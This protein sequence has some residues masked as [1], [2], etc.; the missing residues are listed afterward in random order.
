MV[1]ESGKW[2]ETLRIRI[3]STT[4]RTTWSRGFMTASYPCLF[5]DVVVMNL[6]AM[7]VEKSTF[8]IPFPVDRAVQ[9]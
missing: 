8:A 2:K 7:L 4:V 1:L 9:V 5:L 6:G 3:S